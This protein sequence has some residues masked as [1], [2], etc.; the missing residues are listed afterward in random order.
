MYIRVKGVTTT[1]EEEGDVCH[2]GREVCCGE[3]VDWIL[4]DGG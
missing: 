1:K 3:G 4:R 2:W